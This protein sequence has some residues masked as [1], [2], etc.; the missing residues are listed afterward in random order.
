MD[1]R[2]DRWVR[3]CKVCSMINKTT[4]ACRVL[5]CP[6]VSPKGPKRKVTID[7]MGPFTYF[8]EG[9]LLNCPD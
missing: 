6:V 5:S 9:K 4:K 3:D 2:I 8:S 1:A 7:I